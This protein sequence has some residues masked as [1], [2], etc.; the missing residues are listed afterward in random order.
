MNVTD[1]FFQWYQQLQPDDQQILCHS[2]LNWLQ[3]KNVRQVA[4]QVRF[5]GRITGPA[6]AQV[7]ASEPLHCPKCGA[8]VSQSN[9]AR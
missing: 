2:L 8:E 7:A 9:L 4:P 5:G 6:T 3:P 1:A